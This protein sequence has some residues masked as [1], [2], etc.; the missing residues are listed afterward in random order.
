MPEHLREKFFFPHL[1]TLLVSPPT[2]HTFH[3][4]KEMELF[5]LKILNPH[6]FS[7]K[8]KKIAVYFLE[9]MNMSSFTTKTA[10]S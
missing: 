6:S 7:E 1:P 2:S 3:H 10:E 5:I 4:K 9:P 8:K